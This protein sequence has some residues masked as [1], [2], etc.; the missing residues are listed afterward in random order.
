MKLSVQYLSD[1]KG[2]LKAVQLP[3]EEW[4]RILSILRIEENLEQ[5]HYDMKQGLQ[6]VKELKGGKIKKT[7]IKALLNEL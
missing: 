7:S 3:I 6:E 1:E 4:K 5:F 2:A